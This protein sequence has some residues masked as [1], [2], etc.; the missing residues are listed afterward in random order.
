MELWRLNNLFK[1]F[2]LSFVV[3]YLASIFL[4]RQVAVS[5]YLLVILFIGIVVYAVLIVAPLLKRKSSAAPETGEKGGVS[6]KT[7]LGIVVIILLFAGVFFVVRNLTSPMP[8]Y[9]L[10]S[11]QFLMLPNGTALAMR[12]FAPNNE[13]AWLESMNITTRQKATDLGLPDCDYAWPHVNLSQSTLFLEFENFTEFAY[14]LNATGLAHSSTG[15]AILCF[16][17]PTQSFQC[18]VPPARVT[19][20]R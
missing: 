4:L 19:H 14:D 15:T 7:V 16:T 1:I 12:P 9:Q 8:G 13:C 20:L 5:Q 11:V 18:W 3:A 2:L 17:I 6:R 10:V